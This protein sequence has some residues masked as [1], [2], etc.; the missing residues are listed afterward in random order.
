MTS[1][2]FAGLALTIVAGAMS[3]NCML[4]AKFVV[5][6]K[7]E[8]LWLVFSVVSLVILPWGLALLLVGHLETAYAALKLSKFVA[9]VA[10]GAGWGIAQVLFGI[11]VARLGL[12]VAYS[13]IVGLGAVLGTLVPLFVEQRKSVSMGAL[14]YL[15]AGVLLMVLGIALTAWGG[16]LRE[17]GARGEGPLIE[18]RGYLASVF[19]AVLCGFLAPMLNYAFAFGQEIACQAVAV[20]NSPVRAAYAVWPIALAG[21]FVPNLVYSVYQLARN[22]SVSAFRTPFPDVFL[23]S[24]MAALWMGAFALYGMSAVFLGPLGTSVGWGLFQIFMIATAI[25]SGVLAGEWIGSS[26]RARGY[27]GFGLGALIL[28]TILFIAGDRF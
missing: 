20:G 13:I 9:P 21:G 18:R 11:S 24:A 5:R 3:G 10:F 17:K 23:A 25:G 4:P 28:A 8:N 26:S 2:V 7:W 14:S 12:G 1:P 16:H 22:R 15:L 6:W 27:L 19:L